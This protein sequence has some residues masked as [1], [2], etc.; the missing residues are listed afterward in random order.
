MENI[1][2]NMQ[3]L[4]KI[5]RNLKNYFQSE[6]DIYIKNNVDRMSFSFE[7]YIV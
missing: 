7:N 1:N 3:T 6:N 2:K 4:L 5:A